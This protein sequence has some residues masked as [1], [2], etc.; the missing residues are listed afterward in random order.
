MNMA[1]LT[2]NDVIR[3]KMTKDGYTNWYAINVTSASVSGFVAA[4]SSLPFDNCKTRLQNM[5]P[6]EHGV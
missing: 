4:I 6:D 2:T 5:K 1:M 3:E